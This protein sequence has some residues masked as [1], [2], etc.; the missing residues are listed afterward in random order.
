MIGKQEVTVTAWESGFC[1]IVHAIVMREVAV[2]E[3]TMRVHVA[4]FLKQVV[5]VVFDDIL[6]KYGQN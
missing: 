2:I 6:Q 1:A 5:T 4:H 3:F